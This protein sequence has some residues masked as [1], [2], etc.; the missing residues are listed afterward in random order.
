MHINIVIK[1]LC[2]INYYK[3]TINICQ[4][5]IFINSYSLLIMCTDNLV[6]LPMPYKLFRPW[7]SAARICGA[8][9]CGLD[10]DRWAVTNTYTL[11]FF[12]TI[13]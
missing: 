10:W 11:H 4:C 2:T 6:Y 3:C 8:L 9:E 5:T 12:N 7:T 13:P 1:Y